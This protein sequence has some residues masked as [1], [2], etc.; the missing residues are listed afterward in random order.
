MDNYL[1]HIFGS[2]SGLCLMLAVIN[3]IR[4]SGIIKKYKKLIKG[5]SKENV[6]ELMI[7]Y[8]K[9]LNSVKEKLEHNINARILTLENKM[10]SCIKNVGIVN[11]NAFKNI[12]NNMSFSI[13]A[14]NDNKDGIVFTGIYTRENSYVYAKEIKNGK[15]LK[16]LS[17]EEQEAL[18]KA[19]LKIK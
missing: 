2:L 17:D 14:L 15:G 19:L 11:Y 5:L 10:D 1:I 6:E 7:S 9:E 12:S 3:Y 18:E 8:S 4:L 13:A 16:T